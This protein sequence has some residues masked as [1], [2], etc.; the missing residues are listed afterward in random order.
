MG[1]ELGHRRAKGLELA[2]VAVEVAGAAGRTMAAAVKDC[3]LMAG[4]LQALHQRTAEKSGAADDQ[5]PHIRFAMPAWVFGAARRRL[6][7][8]CGHPTLG[9]IKAR[10][11]CTRRFGFSS[12]NQRNTPDFSLAAIQKTHNMWAAVV[13]SGTLW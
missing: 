1:S 5:N 4:G 9:L 10:R 13:E 8:P 11:G 3:H 12:L 6:N 7:P 2:A